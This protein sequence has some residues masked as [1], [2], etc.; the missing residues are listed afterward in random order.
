MIAPGDIAL[1]IL[2]GGR[3]TRLGGVEKAWIVRDG[4]TQVERLAERFAH[5]VAQTLVSVNRDL[6]RF[7][8]LGLAAVPDRTPDLGPIGG[9]DALAH[10]CATQW[11]L[12]VPVDLVF[13]NDCLLQTLASAGGQGASI[14]DDAGPQPLVALWNV[15]ALRAAFPRPRDSGTTADLSVRVLQHELSMPRVRLKGVRLGNLNTP[16]DLAAVRARL[17]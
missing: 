12:T 4:R 14:D 2:A 8:A 16:A 17:P 3:G 7:E 10:A 9:L 11:L 6:A 5:E 15:Q 13:V 1:G